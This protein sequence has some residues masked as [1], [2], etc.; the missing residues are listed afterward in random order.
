[1]LLALEVG[2]SNTHCGLYEHGA[3]HLLTSF[4]LSTDRNRMPDEWFAILASLID[5]GGRRLDEIDAVVISSVVPTVTSWLLEMCTGRMQIQPLIIDST[6]D[7]GIKLLVGEPEKVGADRIV[8]CVAAKVRYGAPVI[9]IDLGTAT[10][11]DVTNR[12]GDY[13]GGAIAAG[14]G[15]S[16]KG[17]AANAAQLFSIELAMPERVIGTTTVEQLCSGIVLGHVAMLEGL[18]TRTRAEV[19]EAAPTIL[20]GGYASMLKGHSP[21][22]DHI[23][24]DLTIDGLRMIHESMRRG[25]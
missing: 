25:A 8:D 18:I 17:L 23:D 14:I 15:T 13:L 16:L 10:T 4:R 6:L 19:G 3:T 12:D 21:L 7:L 24:P 11:L 20:T 2:N 5:A 1:M 22:F 9:I